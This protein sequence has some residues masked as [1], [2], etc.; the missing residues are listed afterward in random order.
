MSDAWELSKE[1]VLP[2]KRGRSAAMLSDVLGTRSI[3]KLDTLEQDRDLYFAEQL[4][5]HQNNPLSLLTTYE[6][7]FKWYRDNFPSDSSRLI[8]LLERATCDLKDA[9]T[10][11]NDTRFIKMWIE[12]ADLVRTPGDIFAFMNSNKIG[13][14]NA[15]FWIAWS[16]V[17]EKANNFK[18]SDQ[19]FQKGIKRLAE[20]KDLLQK[21]YQQ[22]QRRLARHYINLAESEAAVEASVP[23]EEPSRRVLGTLS[24]SQVKSG[25]RT[26]NDENNAAFI[27]KPS[28]APGGFNKKEKSNVSKPFEIYTDA[29]PI[30]DSSAALMENKNWKHLG[31]TH[32]H[33][34]ENAGMTTKWSDAPLK[35]S[36]VLEKKPD[37]LPFTIF[38]DESLRDESADLAN[39]EKPTRSTKPALSVR[40]EF[41]KVSLKSTADPLE[42]HKLTT[43]PPPVFAEDTQGAVSSKVSGFTIYSD[44]IENVDGAVPIKPTASFATGMGFTI[45]NDFD[46][47]STA[48]AVNKLVSKTAV[49]TKAPAYSVTMDDEASKEQGAAGNRT[50]EAIELNNLLNEIGVYDHDDSTINTRLARKD[51]DE[52]FCS[53]DMKKSLA[54][55]NRSYVATAHTEAA[56]TRTLSIGDL[57][58]IREVILYLA[59]L[60]KVSLTP[61]ARRRATTT[62]TA[63]YSAPS[64][65]LPLC[66]TRR[67]SLI[68][69]FIKCIL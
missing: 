6:N 61:F 62:M 51:I 18:L 36:V 50:V 30:G 39:A 24:K 27:P 55:L 14:K 63:P 32:G 65:H 2:V 66:N 44:F 11:A 5:Q 49:L 37:A 53:P 34:K 46:P 60:I 31:T 3:R 23:V 13:E 52:M 59:T 35:S 45:Y 20:P 4:K 48:A 29:A 22:F 54:S 58:N 19:I 1:N 56:K 67:F 40:M 21:R 25:Q 7:Q 33:S 47:P 69:Y 42:R 15:L 26:V 12:Y 64:P 41:D 38:V 10:C 28:T 57:S 9:T 8:K 68:A 17:A 43:V 16:Y